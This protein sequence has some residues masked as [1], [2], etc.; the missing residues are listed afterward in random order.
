MEPGEQLAKVH[1]AKQVIQPGGDGLVRVSK[2]ACSLRQGCSESQLEAQ[3]AHPALPASRWEEVFS[4]H[5]ELESS[6]H[7]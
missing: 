2:H 4:G 7:A 3:S 1:L 5:C 6:T